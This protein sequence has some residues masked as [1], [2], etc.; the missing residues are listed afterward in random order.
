M[1]KP[2]PKQLNDNDKQIL[3]N[4][5]DEF[6]RE[7]YIPSGKYIFYDILNNGNY[8]NLSSKEKKD[9]YEKARTILTAEQMNKPQ[10]QRKLYLL[11]GKRSLSIIFKANV[12]ILEDYFAKIDADGKHLKDI[13]I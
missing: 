13:L 1:E 10:K 11:S 4:C 12:L 2:Q 7:E 9:Y 8:I 3:C 5:F 6:I